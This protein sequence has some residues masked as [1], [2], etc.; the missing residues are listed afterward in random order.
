MGPQVSVTNS[1]FICAPMFQGIN[2]LA[3][4]VIETDSALT[5]MDAEVGGPVPVLERW[6]V[7]AYAGAYAFHGDKVRS[8]GGGQA[9]LLARISNNLDFNL[10]VRADPVFGGT[11]AFGGAI[12]FGGVR[13]PYREPDRQSTFNRF[14]DPVQRNYNISIAS[15]KDQFE[16]KLTD[17]TTGQPIVIIHVDNTAPAGGDGSVNNPINTLAPAPAL[18]GQFGYILVNV[19]NGTSSGMNAGVSLLNGQHLLGNSM[20]Y[21]FVSNELGVCT[22]PTS[23]TGTPAISNIGGGPVVT[24]NNNNEVAGFIINGNANN[25]IFGNGINNFSIHDLTIP[26]AVGSGIQLINVSGV[27]AILNVTESGA[28]FNGLNVTTSGSSALTLAVSNSSFSS[29]ALDGIN[30]T[31]SGS[32][33]LTATVNGGTLSNNGRNGIVATSSS[34]ASLSLTVQNATI[35]GNG[36]AGVSTALAGSG[37]QSVS[38]SGNTISSGTNTGVAIAM[39]GTGTQTASV[40]NNS[41]FVP[42]TGTAIN[43]AQT[44]SGGNTASATVSNNTI[45]GANVGIAVVQSGTRP[46]LS[47]AISGNN[48]SNS[49]TGILATRSH[50]LG[51][52]S[53]PRS[54]ATPP[55]ITPTTA[56]TSSPSRRRRAQRHRLQQHRQQQR[57][58]RRNAL[59]GAPAPKSGTFSSNT[60]SGNDGNSW[61][62][63]TGVGTRH[64]VQQHHQ[65][66]RRRGIF[67]DNLGSCTTPWQA[68]RSRRHR[69]RASA[70]FCAQND[71]PS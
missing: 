59:F 9:R 65:Q 30:L 21:H 10:Q 54:P 23:P 8:F 42:S 58:R 36:I 18:A 19:G 28:S 26:A 61:S 37:S 45:S 4:H 52:P 70:G 16:Q 47:A 53:P 7:R 40:S 6:G 22:L 57:R 62:L 39:S 43:I 64:H 11:V 3:P 50:W 66:Q 34:P 68:T 12:R 49:G 33:S 27:G 14:A 46:A 13:R 71:G 24:L 67:V 56:S 29:N 20:L 2:I 32:S 15:H 55:A 63:S 5:G 51:R 25:A 17:P 44:E 48:T 35:S 60:A 31:S 69:R 41:V 1:Y 38:L